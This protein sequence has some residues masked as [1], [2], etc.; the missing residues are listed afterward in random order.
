MT[1][2]LAEAPQRSPATG[3]HTIPPTPLDF[4]PP[5]E[6]TSPSPRIRPLATWPT[7][8]GRGPGS[9]KSRARLPLHCVIRASTPSFRLGRVAPLTSLKL[10]YSPGCHRGR[11]L[12]PGA[13]AA[14]RGAERSQIRAPAVPG[15]VGRPRTG[16][17]PHAKKKEKKKKKTKKN[18]AVQT[19]HARRSRG[20][21]GEPVGVHRSVTGG[22]GRSR[23]GP[24]PA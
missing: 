2:P 11:P 14:A 19:R 5:L 15:A 21:P 20:P 3:G 18:T 12:W 17:P 6:P 23:C 24:A 8:I 1:V 9:G 13:P 16:R 22:L 7:R 10:G 4:P